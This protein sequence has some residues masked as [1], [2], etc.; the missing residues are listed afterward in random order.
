[1]FLLVP[2]D[3]RPPTLAFPKRLI[4][5]SGHELKLPPIAALNKL[6]EAGSYDALRGWLETEA[7][8]SD[9]LILSLEQLCLGGMI[10]ARRVTD[11][12]EAALAKLLLLKQL[13][14]LNP[15]LRILAFGVIVRVA[16]GNDPLEEKPYYADYGDALR[17]YSEAF[18]RFQREANPEHE[19]RLQRCIKALPATILNDWLSTRKRNHLLHLEA[20]ELLKSGVLEHLCLTLDDT[21]TYGLAAADRRAL[22]AR[23][24]ALSLWSQV[25]IYPGADEVPSTLIARALS[26]RPNKVYLHYSGVFG[27]EAELLF[28]DRPAGELV[29]AQLRA[30][31][32]SLVG[33]PEQ[34][35]FILA[36]NT[37]ATKQ[38]HQQPDFATVDT[39]ARHLPAFVDFIAQG[40]AR[41]QA[42]SLADIAYPNGSEQRLMTLL[43]RLDL[44]ELA[45]FSG[46]NTA[47]NSLGTA[48]AMGVL[49]P[50]M[51]DDKAF[52]HLLFDRL[53]DDYLY[54]T[55]V[56]AAV[57]QKLGGVNPFD[58]GDMKTVAEALINEQLEPL[59]RA[60]WQQHFAK[61]PY[62]L[63]WK[64][65]RLSWPRLFTLELNFDLEDKDAAKN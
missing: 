63:V 20:L 5:A 27:P 55:R 35:D 9:V 58:L 25:D 43:E 65:P 32:C 7:K 39:A 21:S 31:R 54:Q 49:R 42:I 24:D 28:E 4:E 3:T 37:P 12:L 57:D 34:A 40:L 8:T 45:G 18:D 17:A 30:A 64:Q 46:W 47:G 44:T 23:A 26:P 51:R 59:A 6:N 13:K 36:V 22:E 48:I 61:L 15:Q 50:Q 56:R 14:Q 53:V 29:K 10:P 2:P 16:H 19:N 41:Q 33:S 52:Y 1:M 38:A 60:L 11:S 62:H